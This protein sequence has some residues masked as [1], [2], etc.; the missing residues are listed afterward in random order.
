MSHQN[1]ERLK[2][3]TLLIAQCTATGRRGRSGRRA[4]PR[5]ARS[6]CARAS[7][8]AETPSLASADA[9]ASGRRA[10]RSTA[11]CPTALV[12]RLH[13]YFAHFVDF[14]PRVLTSDWIACHT[15]EKLPPPHT[16]THDLVPSLLP[17]SSLGSS[18]E[19][20]PLGQ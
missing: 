12:S 15:S 3:R 13:A 20:W 18:K 2:P 5:A 4:R 19:S 8:S 17:S 16:H 14:V 9:S 7:A 10:R 1:H 6:Q 11:S